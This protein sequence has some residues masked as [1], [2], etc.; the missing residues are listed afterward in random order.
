M[1]NVFMW[2]ALAC[3]V[4]AA[5]AAGY[6]GKDI[7]DEQD[8]K[9]GIHRNDGTEEQVVAT[10]GTAHLPFMRSNMDITTATLRIGG[11]PRKVLLHVACRRVTLSTFA[12]CAWAATAS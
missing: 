2:V 7:A 12:R 1:R 4:Q 6:D 10:A 9:N 5:S 3:I 11:K 8:G